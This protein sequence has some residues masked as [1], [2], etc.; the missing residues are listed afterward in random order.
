[1]T[2]SQLG[3]TCD[4]CCYEHSSGDN[5]PPVENLD[6]ERER[7]RLCGVYEGMTDSEIEHLA[8]EG[9]SA[10]AAG[11]LTD[12]IRRSG[13][14]VALNEPVKAESPRY[15]ALRFF[16][17]LHRIYAEN[18]AL[19]VRIITPAAVLGSL[20]VLLAN[21]RVAALAILARQQGPGSS[22]VRYSIAAGMI[23]LAAIL[24]SWLVSV[25]ALA[26]VAAAI[27][28]I[29]DGIATTAH[30]CYAKAKE[31]LTR[32]MILA[33]ILFGF[34][35]LSAV[36]GIAVMTVL[37]VKFPR[38]LPQWA[39]LAAAYTPAVL[40]FTVA[41]TYSLSVPVTVLENA[42][43]RTA[44]R[45]S[46]F[47]TANSFGQLLLLVLECL[48]SGY[49]A[50]VLPWWAASYVAQGINWPDWG[51]WV[52]WAVSAYG[53]AMADLIFLIG[54]SVLYSKLVRPAQS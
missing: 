7:Q 42:G 11:V 13:L 18:A 52:V 1:M 14:G 33:V 49:L 25:V 30:D 47:L 35:A 19:L 22:F 43:V 10:I 41:A 8:G 46:D 39:V 36:A 38:A 34:M 23:R 24:F 51:N 5:I 26:A 54:L 53:V 16:H 2:Q 21:N 6:S 37:L 50:A 32:I 28:R 17:E 9:L 48:A 31:H 44:L 15:P 4:K 45:R 3:E 20:A 12:E 29:F 27:Q 40:G